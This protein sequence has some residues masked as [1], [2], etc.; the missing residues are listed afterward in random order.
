MARKDIVVIGASAGGM[1]A[2]QKVV[3]RFPPAL[4]A[5]VFVVWHRSPGLKSILPAVLQRSGPLRAE[6]ARDG[7]RI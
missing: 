1:E 5:S 3:G 2:L 6:H 4:P 7:D